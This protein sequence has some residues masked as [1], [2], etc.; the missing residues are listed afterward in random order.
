MKLLVSDIVNGLDGLST[1]ELRQV[2]SAVIAALQ[3]HQQKIKSLFFVGQNVKFDG[4]YGDK[5]EGVIVSKGPKNI[6][7]RQMNEG[8]HSRGGTNWTVSPGLLKVM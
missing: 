5:L 6:K 2:N 8:R 3:Y 7:V 1:T 4:K